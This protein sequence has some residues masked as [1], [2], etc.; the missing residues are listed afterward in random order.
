VFGDYNPPP[1]AYKF[2]LGHIFTGTLLV[3]KE[4]LRRA[5]PDRI[6]VERK[7]GTLTDKTVNFREL[8][9]R[10]N[11]DAGV[12]LSPADCA[13]LERAQQQRNAIEHHE[14]VLPLREA[15]RLVE[16]LV[17]FLECFLRQ[18]LKEALL[19]VVSSNAAHELSELGKIS[20]YL[21]QVQYEEWWKR[22]KKFKR[23]GK[24]R[25][26]EM[27]VRYDPLNDDEPQE[28]DACG[29]YSVMQLQ[30]DI[31]VCTEEDCRELHRLDTC[32]RCGNLM[33]VN[34]IGYCDNCRAEQR[35]QFEKDD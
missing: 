14:T 34:R 8:L 29:S 23:I 6:F 28:C 35:A 12:Q 26:A 4:R 7:D 17:E 16:S 10:L 32:N 2:G 20:D 18:E 3:L 30:D 11:A 33:V 25:V 21:H 9:D 31:A 15:R 27:K 13:V 22:A 5:K 1:H 19:G 24:K